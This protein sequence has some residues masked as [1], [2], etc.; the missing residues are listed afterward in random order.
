MHTKAALIEYMENVI[1]NVAIERMYAKQDVS[2]IADAHELLNK[3]FE[4]LDTDYGIKPKQK[5][6]PT[7]QAR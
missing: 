6:D 1:A 3:V 5:K 4:Q 7:N 2:H